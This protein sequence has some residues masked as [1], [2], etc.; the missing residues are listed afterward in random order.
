LVGVAQDN[1]EKKTFLCLCEGKTLTLFL[2]TNG[3]Q[4]E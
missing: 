4:Y 2:K 3:D 1:G